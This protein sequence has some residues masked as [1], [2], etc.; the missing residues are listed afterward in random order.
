[1]ECKRGFK[2]HGARLPGGGG[3]K[4]FAAL[5]HAGRCRLMLPFC[6]CCIAG[7]KA[8]R[9]IETR[10]FCCYFYLPRTSDVCKGRYTYFCRYV[11]SLVTEYVTTSAL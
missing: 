11:P 2:R 10:C 4:A 1:M 9:Q 5:D 3:G 7:P 8:A 6:L